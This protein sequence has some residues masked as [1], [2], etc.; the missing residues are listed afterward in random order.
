MGRQMKKRMNNL[1]ARLVISEWLLDNGL[2]P[3]NADL[4]YAEFA[5]ALRK[6]YAPKL[7]QVPFVDRAAAVAYIRMVAAMLAA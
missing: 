3:I 4:D 7:M 6:V 1:S 5:T 2:E